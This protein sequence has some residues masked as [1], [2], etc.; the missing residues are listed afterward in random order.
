MPNNTLAPRYIS[1]RR[2]Q[3]NRVY[4]GGLTGALSVLN[5]DEI[6]KFFSPFGYIVNIDLPK[7]LITGMNK[8]H[9]VIEFEK[10]S[11][12]KE[13][14]QTMDGIEV[15]PGQTLKVNVLSDEPK[16]VRQYYSKVEEELGED[17]TNTYLHSA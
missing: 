6:K 15:A 17:A 1:S 3:N 7:D 14:A 8:G 12:A 11:H 4:V 2:D 16:E 9:A 10:H 5:A 13:A